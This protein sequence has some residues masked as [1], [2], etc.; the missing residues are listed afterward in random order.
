MTACGVSIERLAEAYARLGSVQKVGAEVGLC[1]QTVHYHLRRAGLNKPKNLMTPTDYDAVW[2]Y[3]KTTPPAAFSLAVIASRLGR[4][5]QSI[6]RYARELGLTTYS[7]PMAAHVSAAMR[8]DRK[9][10]WSD[11]PHPRGMAG[12]KHTPETLAKVGDTSRRNWVHAKETGTGLMSPEVRAARRARATA[13]AQQRSPGESYSRARRGKRPDIGPWFFRSSWEANYAR[14]LQ[15]LERLGKIE[16]WEYEPE[17]FV[18]PVTSGPA[19]YLPD[20]KVWDK[21]DGVYFVEIKGWYDLKSKQRFGLMH[22]YR[23][24]VPIRLVDG[25]HWRAYEAFGRKHIKG[26]EDFDRFATKIASDKPGVDVRVE[27]LEPQGE[28]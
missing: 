13:R 12:K 6:A 28:P 24:D 1:G 3:Y 19:S 9:G 10:F 26:W 17:R 4:T 25:R 27:P 22:R 8:E 2:T 14:F 7:R 16:R 15:L 11:R 5:R 23:P 18:F 21:E 20:F